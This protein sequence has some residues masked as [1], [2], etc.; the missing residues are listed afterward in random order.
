MSAP[1][2]P[3]PSK[4]G[5]ALAEQVK[6]FPESPGVYIM[7]DAKG[8]P[9]YVGKAGNLRRRA[10]GYFTS[11]RDTRVLLP[12]LLERAAEIQYLVTATESEALILENN[13]IKKFRPAYNVA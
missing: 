13:L 2:N 4:H 7:L 11:H 1:K 6:S 3:E 8:K 9:I 5:D 10:G 12:L